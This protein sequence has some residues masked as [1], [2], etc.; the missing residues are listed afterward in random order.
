MSDP[1]SIQSAINETLEALR[2]A[3]AAGDREEAARLRAE[4]RALV[5]RR[6][7][8]EAAAR[9]AEEWRR[10]VPKTWATTATDDA[11]RAAVH[12]RL[13]AWSQ[14]PAISSAVLSGPTGVGK[15]TAAAVALRS[16]LATGWGGSIG[17][18]TARELA[19]AARAWPLGEGEAPLLRRARHVGILVVDDLGLERDPAELIDVV[20]ARYEASAPTWVTTGLSLAAL[21]TR[22]GDAVV[23]RLTERATVVVVGAP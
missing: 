3:K 10:T 20:H 17:W 5:A 22:Y 21:E 15:S 16:V 19:H 6:T 1:T 4:G 11:L 8:A 13:W 14:D 7:A 12:P 23:R 2:A 9:G 18:H